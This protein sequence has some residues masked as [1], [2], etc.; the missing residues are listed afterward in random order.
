MLLR[1]PVLLAIGWI[2]TIGCS[3][4]SK[5]EHFDVS[6]EDTVTDSGD[7][8]TTGVDSATAT[9]GD[10]VE[11]SAGSDSETKDGGTPDP[12]DGGQIDLVDGGD[13]DTANGD[14]DLA[15]DEVICVDNDSDDWCHIFDCEDTESSIHPGAEEDSEDGIDNDCDGLTDE[16]DSVAEKNPELWYAVDTKL[17]YIPIDRNTATVLDFVVGDLEGLPQGH[18]CLTML[19]DGSLVGARLGKDDSVS[20]FYFIPSPPRDGTTVVPEQL[21][22]MPDKIQ[23]EGLYTDC[24]GRLYGMDTGK[25]VGSSEGNRLL[26]FT[27]NYL[28]GDFSYQVVSDLSQADVAD[29]DDLGPG[30]GDDGKITDNPGLAIDSGSIYKFNYETGTGTKVAA[31]GT[32]GIHALGGDLFADGSSRVYL[33]SSEAELLEYDALTFAVSGVL[34]QGPT[35]VNGFAGWSGLAGPLTDCQTGFVN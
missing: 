8:A 17:V 16:D 33:L 28:A 18:N 4:D 24:D 32:W 25:D 19:E 31:G 12:T 27:G 7:S 14:S 13:T 10:F 9:T 2:L 34:K 21:G 6:T 22:I 11:D 23:L 3:K 1:L 30:I 20:Y 35:D 26:R 5:N 29:I 15:T